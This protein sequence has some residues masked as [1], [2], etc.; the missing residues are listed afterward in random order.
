MAWLLDTNVISELRK[1]KAEPKVLAFLSSFPLSDLYVSVVT[2]AEIRF[3]IELNSDLQR[4]ADLQDWLTFRVRPMFDTG[5]TLPVTEEILLKWRLLLE[6]GRK[7]GHTFS[8]PDLL[9]AAIAAHHG[10]TVVTRDRIH[11]DRAGVP[12]VNP[13]D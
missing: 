6:E 13:W 2:L 1:P 10:L 4:R 7:T 9:I 3:G 5:R 11:F 12:V 8:Q